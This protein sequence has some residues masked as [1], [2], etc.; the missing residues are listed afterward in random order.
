[1]AMR[2]KVK[3]YLDIFSKYPLTPVDI[4][5]LLLINNGINPYSLSWGIGI[6]IGNIIE[7]LETNLYIKSTDEGWVLRSK[8]KEIFAEE[9]ED[10]KIT[11][12]LRYLNEKIG[13]NF[14]VDSESNRRFVAG[15][16][17][18]G[19]KVEDLKRV[20]DVMV[21]KWANDSKMRFFLR[22]ETL[23]NPTKFQTYVNIKSS[24]EEDKDWTVRKV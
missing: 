15:R 19:Y 3:I 13:K 22:P 4:V 20:V 9:E 8:G 21:E 11:E 12:V 1:M 17:K 16:L 18:D 2:K 6:E 23:F 24:S 7:S 5:V 10:K 14:D